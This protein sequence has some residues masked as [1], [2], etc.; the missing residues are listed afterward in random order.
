M[1]YTCIFP[2]SKY[3]SNI[4]SEKRSI[5][6]ADGTVQKVRLYSSPGGSDVI[7]CKNNG[8]PREM[9]FFYT[10]TKFIWLTVLIIYY[11][12]L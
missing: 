3:P 2:L 10:V 1:F 12:T 9:F 7:V 5:T 8:T 6:Q 11:I 4:D